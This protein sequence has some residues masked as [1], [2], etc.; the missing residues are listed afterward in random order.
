MPLHFECITFHLVPYHAIRKSWISKMKL[1]N[2]NR[3][4]IPYQKKH[5]EKN[6]KSSLSQDAI[7]ARDE[8]LALD[9]QNWLSYPLLNEHSWLQYPPCLIGNTSTHSGSISSFVRWSRSVSDSSSWFLHLHVSV[10]QL[11][12]QDI[13]SLFKYV[14]PQSLF[15][16]TIVWVSLGW[17]NFTGVRA[18]RC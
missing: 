4:H 3:V 7:V 15:R 11:A 2:L 14:I 10:Q 5:M 1:S 16:L 13:W 8:G 17:P 18:I 9:P 12:S 6:D